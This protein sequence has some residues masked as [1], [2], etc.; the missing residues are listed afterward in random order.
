M[1]C[2]SR[3][4][5]VAMPTVVSNCLKQRYEFTGRGDLQWFLGIE[6]IRDRSS[7]LIYL[8][9]STY[10]D[11]IIQL[12][13]KVEVNDQT[14]ISD[15]ELLPRERKVTI[16]EI[17]KYQRKIG[18]IIYAIVTTRLDI[19]FIASRLLRFLINLS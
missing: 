3:S 16:A 10:I 6:V 11:K 14:P 9:Q 15:V 2:I 18:S 19:V 5:N 17:H 7:R 4:A 1:R 12:I 8:S 13:E